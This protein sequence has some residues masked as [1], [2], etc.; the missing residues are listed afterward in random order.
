MAQVIALHGFLGAPSDWDGFG[1]EARALEPAPHFLAWAEKFC[2]GVS[3]RPVLLGY[4]MG[5][6]LAMHAALLAPD[7]FSGVVLVSGNPGLANE[8]ERA[9]RLKADEAWARRFDSSEDWSS[10]LRDWNAQA[11]FAGEFLDR[12]E[13]RRSAAA[14]ALRAWSLGRQQD[15]APFLSE[16][17]LPVFWIAGERDEK[18][19]RI[20]RGMRFT[21]PLSRTWLAPSAAH[22]VPW[23]SA[24]EFRARVEEW[25][26]GI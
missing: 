10:L 26:G 25:V 7:L 14:H 23:E 5:A 20:A 2:A 17:D 6:R 11:V 13:S 1:Y 9:A 21:N 12:P 19:A 3:G 22:R 15:L 4:S 8:A 16:L 24:G 18:F